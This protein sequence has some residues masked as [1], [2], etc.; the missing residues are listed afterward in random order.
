VALYPMKDPRSYFIALKEFA[1][2]VS[3]PEVLV[4]DA[5]L[6][7]K[8][9]EVKEFLIQNG[10]TLRVFKAETQW[11]NQAELYIGLYERGNLERHECNRFPY[12]PMGLLYGTPSINLPSHS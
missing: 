5:N 11:A 12:C 3:V 6:T 9:W 1:K 8:K 10:T 2:D 7:Q 4:C